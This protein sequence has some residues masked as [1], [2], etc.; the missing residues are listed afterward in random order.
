MRIDVPIVMVWLAEGIIAGLLVMVGYEAIS[1]ALNSIRSDS[2]NEL[3]PSPS[4]GD[5]AALEPDPLRSCS[6]AVRQAPP[7]TNC[8]LFQAHDGYPLQGQALENRCHRL[9]RLKILF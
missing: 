7:A 4:Q 9:K 1:H 2:N 3:D 8:G 6:L 5:F